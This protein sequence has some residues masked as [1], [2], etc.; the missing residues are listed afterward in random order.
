MSEEFRRLEKSKMSRG[1]LLIAKGSD[2]YRIDRWEI[3]E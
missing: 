3:I 2:G 1:K